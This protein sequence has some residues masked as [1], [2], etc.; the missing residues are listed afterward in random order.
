V[1]ALFGRQTYVY[2]KDAALLLS[3]ADV[4][5]FGVGPYWLPRA[6]ASLSFAP[7]EVGSKR[8]RVAGGPPSTVGRTLSLKIGETGLNW[9]V[10]GLD[11]IALAAADCKDDREAMHGIPLQSAIGN[12]AHSTLAANINWMRKAAPRLLQPLQS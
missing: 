8:I 4:M 5:I 6:S 10:K 3:Y 11:G 2:R 9:S 1:I 12:W 7:E